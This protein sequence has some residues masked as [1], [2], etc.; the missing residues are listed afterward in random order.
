MTD[1]ELDAVLINLDV[2]NGP[3]EITYVE[4]EEVRDRLLAA[5]PKLL[6]EVRDLIRRGIAIAGE[7]DT[8]RFEIEKHKVREDR[9]RKRFAEVVTKMEIARKRGDTP[10][11]DDIVDSRK[12]L[13]KE[14]E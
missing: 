3:G 5:V 11:L 1:K 12:L 8:L 4:L 14:G 7:R 13:G 9:L 10:Y 6:D 2:L